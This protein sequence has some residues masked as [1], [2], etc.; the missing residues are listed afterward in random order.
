MITRTITRTRHVTDV[1]YWL[2]KA[3]SE[4]VGGCTDDDLSEMGYCTPAVVIAERDEMR[5][6]AEKAEAECK[7]LSEAVR[8][9][10]E[11]AERERSI[12]VNRSEDCRDYRRDIRRLE[13]ELARLRPVVEAARRFVPNWECH[14]DNDDSERANNAARELC[15]A[16]RALDGQ[17]GE[18]R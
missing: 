2:D 5:A 9:A 3:T 17:G 13:S 7:R 14:G 4:P 16:V 18:S 12:E 6:R 1:L 8:E 10:E 11:F 15:R